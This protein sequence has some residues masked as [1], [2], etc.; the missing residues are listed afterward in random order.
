[1]PVS[2]LWPGTTPLAAQQSAA[3]LRQAEEEQRARGLLARLRGAWR[4]E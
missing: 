3:E 2:S 1:M 4:D